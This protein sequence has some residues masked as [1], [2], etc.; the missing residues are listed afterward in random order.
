MGRYAGDPTANFEEINPDGSRRLVRYYQCQAALPTGLAPTM[1]SHLVTPGDR[2]DL[3]SARYSGDP[4]GFWR[5][6]DANDALDP[7]LLVAPE[8]VGTSI[9]IPAPGVGQA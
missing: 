2:L 8:A 4:L 9:K 7:D 3:I 5:I 6:A 1:V